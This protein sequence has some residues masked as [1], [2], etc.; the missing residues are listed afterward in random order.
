MKNIIIALI[1]L[2]N[3]TVAI[4][5]SKKDGSHIQPDNYY[6][7]VM[8]HTSMGNITVELYRAKAP[9]AVNN[10][11]RYVERGRYEGLLFHRIVPNFVVQT[12]GYDTDFKGIKTF[13]KIF[14]ESGNG[15]KNE[16]YTIAMARDNDPHSAMSQFY[17]NLR[18]NESLDPGK[19]WGYTV[20]GYV[21]EG[22]EIID[23]MAEV[24][25]EYNVTVRWHDVPKQPII[26]EKVTILPP[27][28]AVPAQTST[29][30]EEG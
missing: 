1:I 29:A 26:L 16:A 8:L 15:L 30:P 11:L 17:F 5:Q 21:T 18:D 27:F 24:E 20:F 9:I 12:G 19:N 3:A 6:P 14:N 4:A 23:A 7:K 10:F 25:T 2:F 28:E 22:T 13:P